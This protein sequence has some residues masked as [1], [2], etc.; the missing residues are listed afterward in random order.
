MNTRRKI[1]LLIALFSAFAGSALFAAAGEI[2]AFQARDYYGAALEPRDGI[3]TGA[4]QDVGGFDGYCEALG[5]GKAPVIYMFYTGMKANLE[6]DFKRLAREMD[7][8]EKKTGSY[9]IAQVGLAMTNDGTPSDHFEQDVAAGSYDYAIDALCRAIRDLGHPVIL[10]I[11][12]E[13]NGLA[14]NGYRSESYKAAFIRIV[15][16]IRG[17]NLECA[18]CWDA[19]AVSG[20][21]GS[22]SDYYPGDQWVDWWGINLFNAT[23]FTD[24]SVEKFMTDARAHKKPVLIGESTPKNVGVLKGAAS[25]NAWFVKYFTFVR[26]HPG[27]KAFSYIN[28][29]FSRYPQWSDW[30][31]SRLGKNPLVAKN[32]ASEMA[33]P[34]YIQGQDEPALRTLL[35]DNA[36]NAGTAGSP[37][38]PVS[39]AGSASGV[40]AVF[41]DTGV[42]LSWKADPAARR[43]EVMRA[44]LAV[45][46]T[47]VPFFTDRSVAAGETA[48][49]RIEAIDRSGR[50]VSPSAPVS[51]VI[52]PRIEKIANGTFDTIIAPWGLYAYSG[53]RGDVAIDT[54]G[55]LGTGSSARIAVIAGKTNWF[56]QFSQGFATRAGKSYTLTATLKA[57]APCSITVFL[58][59]AHE[60]YTSIL[61]KTVSLGKTPTSITFTNAQ[62]AL[63]DQLNLAFMLGGNAGRTIWLDSV[64]LVE[65]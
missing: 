59:Q 65:E 63:D 21:M 46:T 40:T 41:K 29:D 47:G 53:G 49:Y 30:G 5:A 13:F 6:S 19:S 56:V 50:R 16:K 44:G 34:E 28:W 55:A 9:T 57:D 10:R 31:D 51:V 20:T 4:G 38:A 32:F 2:P 11:G 15:G 17:Y 12:Y 8:V 7:A 62:P 14:W 48:E 33:N 43:W 35:A 58:Q 36:G 52:P 23:E 37:V 25:W 39:M 54:A 1:F 18:T 64:S 27:V 3:F 42:A 60:P 22:V 45:G 26:E 24:G 61:E